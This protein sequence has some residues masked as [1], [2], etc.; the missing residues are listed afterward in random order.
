[1]TH[2]AQ[3]PPLNQQEEG[4]PRMP[5]NTETEGKESRVVVVP[6]IRCSECGGQL[7]YSAVF[8]RGVWTLGWTP[9]SAVFRSLIKKVRCR[10]ERPGMDSLRCFGWGRLC[11]GSVRLV[12]VSV[13][14]C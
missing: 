8:R 11:G 9:A 4:E 12:L 13:C 6:D 2:T 5:T 3:P 10:G 7:S 14:W 1:M